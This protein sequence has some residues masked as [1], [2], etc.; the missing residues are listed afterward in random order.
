MD[1][2]KD[3]GYIGLFV[4]IVIFVFWD[5]V[6]LK[7]AF[8]KGDYAQQFFPWYKIYSDSIKSF[9]L[10]L[11]TN[12][13][14]CGFPLFAEGQ[15]GSLYPFNLLFFF[16]L[17][18]K[19]AY[20]YSFLF[21]F[22]LAGVF[23]Y[24][25]SRKLKAAPSGAFLAAI[26]FCFGSVYAGCFVNTSSLKSLAYFPLVLL[27]FET[28][29]EKRK[30]GFLFLIGVI[31]GLQ[32][33]CGA[34]QMTVY[35]LFFYT[36]YF[37]YRS[38]IEKRRLIVCFKEIALISAISFMISLPQLYFTSELASYSNRQVANLGFSLWN[39]FN[40]LSMIG[41][42]LPYLGGVFTKGNLI[43][44]GVIGFFFVFLGGWVFKKEKT[45]RAL[46][47][48]FVFALFL[49]LGKFN[50]V[51]V[52]LIK[53]FKFYYF[54]APSRFV[55]FVVFSLSILSGLGFSYF[56]R[57][58]QAIPKIIYKIFFVLVAL[59]LGLV[60]TVKAVFYFWGKEMLFFLKG[61]VSKHVF[62][63]VYH[64]YD[65]E[66]YLNKTE[67]FYNEML[68]RF[69]FSNPVVI[70]SIV[71]L[72]L[73][74]ALIYFLNSKRTKLVRSLCFL[75]IFIELFFFSYISSAIRGNLANFKDISP[76]E[77]SVI[78]LLRD[79]KEISR[80][81][82]FGE[83]SS[84]PSWAMPS[85]NAYY[86]IES[87]GFY[88]PLLNRDY[89]LVAQDLGIVDDSLGIVPVK[90]E[91][92]FEKIDLV[93]DLNVKYIISDMGLENSNLEF[94]TKENGS[95]LYRLTGYKKRFE[96][97]PSCGGSKAEIEVKM[98]VPGELS[99]MVRSESSGIFIFREKYY[100][101]WQAT[102]DGKVVEIKRFN[103]IFQSIKVP[104][105]EQKIDFRFQP[106]NLNLFMLVS[107]LVFIF[108]L[109]FGLR[110][111]K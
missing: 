103:D 58:R 40:P 77:V 69:S 93:R 38:I 57:A 51:Y 108:C 75:L 50:P 66:T 10:P 27:L 99:L 12:Y 106:V 46:I 55:Y 91:K 107:G 5:V 111:C 72:V 78:S 68:A 22:V 16:F 74:A 83:F 1:K 24:L 6:I 19:A 9:H 23:T 81:L 82:P 102:I 98:Y 49:S 7:S 85:L 34:M 20:N 15:I 56:S 2:R 95:F 4:V 59:S 3:L 44:V 32:F 53:I 92:L 17:P 86:K 88:S 90:K 36:V 100:P 67:S 14:Q 87:V 21:H 29:L 13:V 8:L 35:A 31:V 105:G 52:L 84:L 70:F 48:M 45:T 61:Y 11:W 89:Y 104:A 18:F 60:L 64:R 41:V 73:S 37:M 39:S 109:W 26:L 28:Y 79:D 71:I 43:Y 76:K 54:R 30:I 63:Q 47:L 101:G 110:R 97:I 65:L 80:I 96:F 25:F 42:F 33:L 94:L 62:G